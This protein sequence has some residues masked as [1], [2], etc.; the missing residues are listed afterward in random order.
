MRVIIVLFLMLLPSMLFGAIETDN[1]TA[2]V[3][4]A[5]VTAAGQWTKAIK[6]A[7]MYIFASFVTIDM[8]LT[9][10]FLALKGTEL[11]EFAGELIRKI[12][13]IGFFLFLFQSVDILKMIPAS[14]AQLALNATSYDIEPDTIIESA[15][16]L[17]SALWNGMSLTDISGSI[18]K[19]LTGIICLAA[20][21]T[22]A[23]QLFMILVKIQAIIAGSYLIFA[24]G[25]L[26]YTRN[27]AINPLKALFAAGM[28]LM[29]IKLFLALTIDTVLSLEHNVGNDIDSNIAIIVMSIIL[30]SAIQM[31][32]GIVNSLMSGTLG[33]NSTSGLAVAAAAAGG[34]VAGTAAMGKSSAGMSDAVKSARAL[35]S[36][37]EG[38][39]FSNLTKAMQQDMANTIRG[40]NDRDTTS[41]G[42]RAA[43]KMTQQVKSIEEA[44]ASSYT[45][46]INPSAFHE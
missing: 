13:W 45:N 10:G 19:I 46:S 4:S 20:F 41:S 43:D 36:A 25:G 1:G 6:P 24:F 11:A 39:T 26:S 32:P 21:A 16:A 15:M 12:M 28:E 29:F 37:G 40:K 35:A 8:V 18:L 23:A 33:G 34:A 22:M 31:I 5:F 42:S 9:F 7:G 27:M 30:F 38:T 14:F 44:N 2:K 17:V 3:L